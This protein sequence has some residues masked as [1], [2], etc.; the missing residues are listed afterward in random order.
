MRPP[1]PRATDL[2]WASVPAIFAVMKV[3]PAMFLVV[4]YIPQ[5]YAPSMGDAEGIGTAPK[6]GSLLAKGDADHTAHRKT[7]CTLLLCTASVETI[8]VRPSS[9]LP[10]LTKSASKTLT[11]ELETHERWPLTRC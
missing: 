9:V 2:L 8:G 7:F 10:A 4:M 1:A 5:D 3:P 11:E 6:E